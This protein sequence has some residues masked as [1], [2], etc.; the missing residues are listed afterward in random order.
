M[1]EDGGTNWERPAV[2]G[3]DAKTTTNTG[4]ATWHGIVQRSLKQTDVKL[5]VYVIRDRF[6][7]GLGVKR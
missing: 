7:R 6:M 3:A 1:G 4:Q 5:I 2:H